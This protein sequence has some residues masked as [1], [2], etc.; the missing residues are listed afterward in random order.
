MYELIAAGIGALSL[1]ANGAIW[2]KMGSLEKGLKEM[3]E[4]IEQITFI[5]VKG[6]KPNAKRRSEN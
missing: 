4:V 5:G 1:A 2:Y 3:Q 6:G